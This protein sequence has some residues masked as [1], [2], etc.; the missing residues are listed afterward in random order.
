MVALLHGAVVVCVLLGTAAA[1]VGM[2]RRHPRRE[3]LYYLLL[4]CV[5]TSQFVR[6]E[7]ILTVLE[8]TLLRAHNSSAV[9]HNSFLLQ[10]LPWLPPWTINFLGPVVLLL[11]LLAYPYWRMRDRLCLADKLALTQPVPL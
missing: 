8:K 4:A 9:Y 7:C 11:S 2:L 6:G 3:K 1:I 5:L 10:Y